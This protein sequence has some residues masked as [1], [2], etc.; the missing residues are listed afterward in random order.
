MFDMWSYGYFSSY[1]IAIK[2]ITNHKQE[3]L[4]DYNGWVLNLVLENLKLS[5]LF[6]KNKKTFTSKGYYSEVKHKQVELAIVW[7]T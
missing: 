7:N 1:P 5:V 3:N 2:V 6:V 4:M